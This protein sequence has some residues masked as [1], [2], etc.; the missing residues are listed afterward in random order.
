MFYFIIANYA[1]ELTASK[2]YFISWFT[3]T[4]VSMVL[5]EATVSPMDN[6]I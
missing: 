4:T 1:N 2:E 5:L 3:S 6:C